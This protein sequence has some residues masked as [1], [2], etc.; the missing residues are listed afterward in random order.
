MT[1][2]SIHKFSA[3]SIIVL[4]MISTGSCTA[5]AQAS[6][7]ASVTETA[8]LIP[9]S[10]ITVTPEHQ[11]TS[12]YSKA[13]ITAPPPRIPTVN[14]PGGLRME[15]YLI[16]SNNAHDEIYDRHKNDKGFPWGVISRSMPDEISLP[17]SINVITKEYNDE[18]CIVTINLDGKDI[19]ATDAAN[20]SGVS[21][22]VQAWGYDNHWAIEIIPYPYPR[23]TTK[24]FSGGSASTADVILDGNSLRE[25]N[26][27]KE[28]F[29]FQL[30]ARKPFFFFR[31]DRGVGISYDG[32]TSNTPF[33]D[34][35]YRNFWPGYDSDPVQY[36]NAVIWNT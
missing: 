4:N 7:T 35:L 12:V 11:P 9:P 30:L 21:G 5:L 6:A 13:T 18:K 22:L 27:Y 8:I 17:N 26:G 31:T 14:L 20:L 36:E 25:T 32:Q 24:F 29:G 33:K 28:V 2:K 23:D 19:Y 15:E 3:L 16:N 1:L 10:T 34:V